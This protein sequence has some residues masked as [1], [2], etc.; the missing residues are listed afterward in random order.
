M[1]KTVDA[2]PQVSHGNLRESSPKVQ[3]CTGSLPTLKDIPKERLDEVVNAVKRA[4]SQPELRQEN[5]R[6]VQA[7]IWHKETCVAAILNE[8]RVQEEAVRSEL[9][10]RI[11]KLVYELNEEAVNATLA[12]AGIK[13]D[14]RI[15]PGSSLQSEKDLDL[16]CLDAKE[17]LYMIL[18]NHDWIKEFFLKYPQHFFENSFSFVENIPPKSLPVKVRV[19]GLGIAGS[20]AVSGLAKNNVEK[21]HGY[22]KRPEHGPRSATSRYQNASW[23]AYDVAQQMVDDQAFQHFLENRQRFNVTFDDGTT[24]IRSSDRV[25]IILGSAVASALES[26]RRYGAELQFSCDTSDFYNPTGEGLEESDIVALFCGAHTANLAPG[27]SD[28]L[29]IHSW[30]ELDSECRMW[31]RMEPSEHT[32]PF[33]TRGG[34]VGCENWDYTIHSARSN[35]QDAQR[36]LDNIGTGNESSI[37]YK[38]SLAKVLRRDQEL[39]GL[40]TKVTDE[41]VE[42]HFQKQLAQTLTVIEAAKALRFDYIFTNA[43]WNAHNLTKRNAAP[44]V[45]LDGT[46]TVEVKLAAR[47]TVMNN[48]ELLKAFG[49]RLIVCGGD[50]CVPPNP[51]AAYGATLACEAAGVL[52]RLAVTTGHLNS[53][54]NNLKEFKN[55]EELV[56]RVEDIKTLMNMHYE[57]RCKSENYFQWVQTLISNVYSVPPFTE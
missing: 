7:K 54:R 56:D 10:Q 31:L 9:F 42:E 24:E 13:K 12:R 14:N 49:T 22:E 36:I 26:A 23:R 46:Y 40:D 17:R 30:P 18:K 8:M 3:E 29:G 55:M 6:A 47:S 51:Q 16:L 21:V 27:L 32:E 53:I 33:C 19:V 4:M 41:L 20:T 25:Q 34:E 35:I 50:A 5:A 11:S 2:L 37:P 52:V 57:A 15:H 45:V 43:P 39:L 48:K 28:A 38:K 44:N 1:T